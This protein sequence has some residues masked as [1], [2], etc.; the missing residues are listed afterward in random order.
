MSLVFNCLIGLGCVAYGQ[1]FDF[2]LRLRD[3]S[4][5]LGSPLPHQD[6]DVLAWQNEGFEQ[7]FLFDSHSIASMHRVVEAN[8]QRNQRPSDQLWVFELYGDN[9]LAGQLLEANE[10][11]IQIL[12]P[13][14]GELSLE[15]T[16]VR[17]AVMASARQW[18]T[19]GY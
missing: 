19:V 13:T 15:R 18:Q 6:A 8:D 7:P 9:L 3:G 10:Q 5:G 1:Q 11:R 16:W 4:I 12:S 2:I 17:C 14:L